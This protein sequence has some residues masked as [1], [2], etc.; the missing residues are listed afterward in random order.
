MEG[1]EVPVLYRHYQQKFGPIPPSALCNYVDFRH[2]TKTIYGNI[3]EIYIICTE[4]VS[5]CQN[6]DI[7]LKT[8]IYVLNKKNELHWT[9]YGELLKQ[10]LN[11]LTLKWSMTDMVWIVGLLVIQGIM[12]F[13]T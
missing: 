4:N 13:E 6:F 1:V 7:N 12:A 3:K 9:Q 11:A 2:R 8:F 10:T 5:L